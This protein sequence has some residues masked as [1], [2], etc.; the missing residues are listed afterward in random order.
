MPAI[1]SLTLADTPRTIH[2]TWQRNSHDR[3]LGDGMC[4]VSCGGQRG[5]GEMVDVQQSFHCGTDR[6]MFFVSGWLPRYGPQQTSNEYC[7]KEIES[8][9]KMETPAYP[10]FRMAVTSCVY[11][12]N[13]E[14][15]GYL[16]EQNSHIS[17]I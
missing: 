17:C 11:G 15:G 14:T 4:K 6:V 9:T 1:L 2:D 12:L 3:L 10:E 13:S 8:Q 16:S 5:L 7:G